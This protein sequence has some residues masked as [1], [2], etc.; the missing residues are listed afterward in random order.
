MLEKRADM[1]PY[2]SQWIDEH[3]IEAVVK[4]LK[5]DFIT[6]GPSI[7]DF[8]NAVAAYVGARYA[9]A[10][11]NGTAAL[12]AACYAAG[13]G[14]GDEVVT[15]PITFLASSNC[16]LYM[17]AKVVFADI[18]PHTYNIDPDEIEAAITDR[19]KAIIAVDLTGQPAEMDRILMLAKDRGIA[20]IHDAAH[21]LGA[22]YGG[23]KVGTF[24][25]MTMFSFHP[26]K[27][28]TTGEGG[29]IVTDDERLKTAL[30]MFRNHGMTRDPNL[31]TRNGEPWYY[32]MQALGYNYRMTD[33]Q[34]ALGL[35]QLS[36]LDGFVRRRRE[37]AARYNA[38][39]EELADVVLPRQHP[40]AESSWHLY[41]IRV[42]DRNAV[43]ARLR[44]L[45]IGVN[46]HYIPV[47]KQPYYRGL[48]YRDDQCQRAEHYYETAI[49]LPL[50]PKM[51]DEDVEDVIRA[52]RFA[53]NF[54]SKSAE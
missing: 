3:D 4:V 35:S 54:N 53:V 33:M 44:D 52:V 43:F 40:S 42:N 11:C 22:S 12:H 7:A 36:K 9:V 32:E 26:V 16:A 5:S 28:V 50:F 30:Q 46:V 13:I 51:S 14:P 20:V 17:G 45:N 41:V 47:Y 15:T 34:A 48:G 21:S 23:S 1:L 6:Q 8:E 37:I 2:G 24:G 10:F 27:H 49:T 38:A 29:V 25:D 19:T 39:F 18:D 31:L